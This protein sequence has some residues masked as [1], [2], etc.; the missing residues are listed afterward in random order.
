MAD[1]RLVGVDVARYLALVGMIATHVI[2]R[3]E[4]DGL[5][6]LEQLST[7]RASALF[8]FLA[9][10]GIALATPRGSPGPFGSTWRARAIGI[11]VRAGV[12]AV[13]GLALGALDHGLAIILTYYGVTFLFAVPFIGL[14]A[15]TLMLICAAWVVVAPVVSQIIRPWLP[16]R[17]Y[18]TPD[19][20]DLVEPP[21]LLSELTFTGYYPAVPWLAYVLA[22]MAFGRL[23]LRSP[24]VLAALTTAGL[25]LAAVATAVSRMLL[26]RPEVVDPLIRSYDSGDRRTL[27]EEIG[28]GMGGTT[29]T[30]GPWQWLLVVA[31]H[32]ATP[33]DLAQTIGTA[34]AV[35]GFCLLTLRLLPP[36]ASRVAAIVFGGGAATLSLYCLHAVMLTPQVWPEEEP[37]TFW[38]HVAVVTVLGMALA[39]LHR[40]GPLEKAV[41]SLSR[42]AAARAG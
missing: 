28:A 3:D 41:G 18:S 34:M 7:G 16:E 20:G 35:T 1:R 22:G 21:R 12:I 14:R 6:G 33:F 24:R 25:V 5:G 17:G 8:A 27:L 9:G 39:L 32:S 19:L 38:W 2:D 37:S 15:R 10:V 36:A 40:R 30:D 29:P 4:S 42:T 23:D 26:R 31:P 13:L 11:A